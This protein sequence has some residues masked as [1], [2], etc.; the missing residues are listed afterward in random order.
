MKKFIV[1]CAIAALLLS[2]CAGNN[3]EISDS[4][5]SITG[6]APSASFESSPEISDSSQSIMESA[7]STS[8]ES[9]GISDKEISDKD[10]ANMPTMEYV[11][12]MGYGINL[13]NTFESC[14]DWIRST[15][16]S[17]YETA[18]GSPVIM[19]KAIQVYAD[20]GFDVLRIPAAWANAMSSDS[21]YTI[22]P[23]N[24]TRVRED[25]GWMLDSRVFVII[26]IHYDSSWVNV[27][28]ENEE[29]NMKRFKVMWTQIADEFNNFDERLM[30]EAQNE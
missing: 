15:D 21:S 9:G 25:I 6:S 10:I 20:V 17:A 14:G 16:V 30:F 22:S 1:F 24:I 18:W 11:R 26:N 19:R 7:P 29:E 23:Q 13:G 4:L 28:T 3:S 8:S 5:L 12:K 2:G 27:F